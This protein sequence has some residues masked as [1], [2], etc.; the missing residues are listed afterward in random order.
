MFINFTNHPYNLWS[1]KEKQAA[2]VYGKMVEIPFPQIAPDEDE[3]GLREIT[4]EYGERITALHP[5]AVMVAGDF[6]TC[7]MLV[8]YLLKANI[9]VIASC[10]RRDT[11]ETKREDG[12]LEKKSIFVFEGF[13]P[14][15]YYQD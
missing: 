5:D 13:R 12:S 4:K 11:V 1:E 3:E 9:H 8:D 2:A 15:R 14:Y 10:A 7:F 6:T